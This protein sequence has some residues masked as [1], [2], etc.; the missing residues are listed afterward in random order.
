MQQD[1]ERQE[2]QPIKRTV[3]DYDDIR[4]M[5]PF[6]DG[7]PKLVKFLM[8][9]ID[10]DD[11]N[12]IHEHNVDTP[13]VPFCTGLLNDLGATIDIRN[14]QV[15]D[16][17][18]DGPFVT[19]SNHPFGALDGIMMIHMLGTRRPDYKFMVNM[20]LSHIS[21]MMP[22]FICVDALASTDPAKR[23]VSMQG[24]SESMRHVKDGHPL[25]FFP[26]GAVS[27]LTR[28]LR[29]EDRE[30]Q[31]T[32]MRLIQKFKVPVIPIYLHGHNSITSYV[33]GMIDW[34]LRTLK[35]PSE[36]F[37]RRNYNF[38]VS[39]GDPIMPD[40]IARYGKP[41]ELGIFLKQSTYSMK[42]WK[43]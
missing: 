14:E 4:K 41:E 29:V 21:G 15:L 27:K 7:K 26:A 25:G 33:L 37:R 12:W 19:V 36:V 34:R 40:V 35:L 39:V 10:L 8:H 1:I 43:E 11:V 2:P 3:L 17:L 24:I 31:P 18:P 20:I 5:V 9:L 23:A 22:N 42:K 30:W 38:R 28:N 13:G 16:N 6:F 32:I